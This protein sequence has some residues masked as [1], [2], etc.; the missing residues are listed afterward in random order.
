MNRTP[1]CLGALGALWLTLSTPLPAP[2]Q[3]GYPPSVE[4]LPQPVAEILYVRPFSL[5]AGYRFT[6][7]AEPRVIDD[8]TLVVAQ[9]DPALL[10][11][12]DE[13]EPILYAG[14]R[15]VEKLNTGYPSGRVIVLVP[16]PF[17][18]AVEPLWVGRPGLPGR[19]T[20]ESIRAEMAAAG[21]RLRVVSPAT[22]AEVSRPPV[23]AADVAELL[24][25]VVA[26]L[27]LEFAPEEEHLAR[28][29]R[30]PVVGEGYE[31]VQRPEGEPR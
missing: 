8:G 6:W 5:A 21:E 2:A 31:P 3:E 1:R 4:T 12:R 19:A 23:A 30:L 15:T 14:Q 7:T 24:R 13:P 18:P 20:P 11:P 22:A 17:D 29:W 9:L 10:L 27:V 28:T 26:D 25:E 16:G